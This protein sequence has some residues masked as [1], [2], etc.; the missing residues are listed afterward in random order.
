MEKNSKSAQSFEDLLEYLEDYGVLVCK[1][2]RFAIQPSAISTHLK[3]HQLY[4]DRRRRLLEHIGQLSL[5]EPS[6]VV[7]PLPNSEPISVL[8]VYNG[9][10]CLVDGCGYNCASFKR[11]QS[12]ESAVHGTPATI[13][14]NCAR[15][16]LQTFFQGTQIKYFQVR[17]PDETSNGHVNGAMPARRQR[18][19]GYGQ[20]NGLSLGMTNEASPGPTPSTICLEDLKLMHH[21]TYATGPT[22]HRGSEP[23]D[24]W[25]RQI[26]MHAS[27][28]EYLMR[29]ILSL[30][31][32]HLAFLEPGNK[33]DWYEI[34]TRHHT[35]ALSLFRT[36]LESPATLDGGT[37]VAFAR[38]LFM[39]KCA[40]YQIQILTTEDTIE[41]SVNALSEYLNLAR[42][43]CTMLSHAISNKLNDNGQGAAHQSF[44]PTE[45][46]T[47]DPELESA[48][49]PG[50]IET[51]VSILESIL[52]VPPEQAELI[53]LE[54]AEAIR[55]AVSL[56]R[57]SF[58]IA[59]LS[60]N[61]PSAAWDALDYWPGS[62][63]SRYCTMLVEQ[64]PAALVI[65]AYYCVLLHWC[66]HD[67]WFVHCHA[68][69]LLE[70]IS[71]LLEND[72]YIELISWPRQQVGI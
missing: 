44:Y 25:T 63:P 56:L 47:F 30:A 12:H 62:L 16:C 4:R 3:R 33:Y 17:S 59:T 20:E 49:L 71:S 45:R 46:I 29:N 55:S 11:I 36:C 60:Q 64:H 65:F 50:D 38:I 39:Y 40:D 61:A 31:A 52:S 42:G 22:L 10:K 34:G 48:T 2:C 43:G 41:C 18:A 68:R 6:N 9:Y 5:A 67:T 19:Y 51:Y 53:D 1:I 13:N 72:S 24:F 14:V 69:F 27:G 21:F 8:P 70:T 37:A 66:A 32:A 54:G 23:S 57:T 7:L 28:C 58:A 35:E 15:T 26:P